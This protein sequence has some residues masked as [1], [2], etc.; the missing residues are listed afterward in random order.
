MKNLKKKVPYQ[1]SKKKVPYQGSKKSTLSRKLIKNLKKVPYQG[2][3]KCLIKL[4][5]E[6]AF[7]LE[8]SKTCHL[9]L[10]KKR[11]VQRYKI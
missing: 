4:V 9:S 1:E 5:W 7:L 8:A 11:D 10:I 3:K 2:S 6:Y